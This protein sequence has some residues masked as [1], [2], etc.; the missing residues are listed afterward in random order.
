[1]AV[2]EKVK[3][4][5]VICTRMTSSRI[6]NKPFHL[7]NG[8]PVLQHLINRLKPL[9]YPIILAVPHNEAPIYETKFPD[10]IIYAGSETDP[11]NRMAS[12]AIALNLQ[13]VIRITHD[14]IFVRRNDIVQAVKEYEEFEAEYLY[15]P[16]FIPGSGFEIISTDVLSKCKDKYKDV[17]FIGYAAREVATKIKV[18]NPRHPVGD[19][20][21]LIDY[22]KDA[23]LLELIMASLGNDCELD[24]V[25]LFLNQNPQFKIINQLPKLTIYTCAYNAS[26]FIEQT[27]R[28]VENQNIFNSI[29]YLIIDDCS[30]DNTIELVANFALKHPNVRWIRNQ[31]NLGLASSSNIALKNATGDYIMRLDADD[32]FSSIHSAETML[33]E[34]KRTGKEAVYPDNY[35]GSFNSV[36]DGGKHFHIGGA[37]FSR[38]ALNYVRFT[39]GLRNHD[40]LDL[41]ARAKDQLKIG[42][43]KKPI[44][45]YRQHEDSMSKTNLEERAK[46]KKKIVANYMDPLEQDEYAEI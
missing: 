13:N 21:L 12:A 34:I 36:Q 10:L 1:M 16:K 9:E 23:Q 29:E 39:D 40:S 3:T 31:K 14:K 17:E 35:F 33:N 28:S 4:G 15:S 8:V 38:T 46:I 6:P 37:I 45:F 24:Q 20:R 2:L 41:W 22:P 18:F 30:T 27:M 7:I 43:I 42:L 44:F 25:I 26:K 11:L 32:F 19:Y 5:I